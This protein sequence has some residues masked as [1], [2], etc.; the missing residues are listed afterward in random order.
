MQ[1]NPQHL[2]ALDNQGTSRLGSTGALC[3][4]PGSAL[5]TWQNGKPSSTFRPPSITQSL[6]HCG[7]RPPFH[8]SLQSTR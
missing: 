8:I 1:H 4:T 7:M 3:R 2:H 5:L 6:S